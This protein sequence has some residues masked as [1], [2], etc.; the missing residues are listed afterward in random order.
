MKKTQYFYNSFVLEVCLKMVICV[1]K[2]DKI[3]KETTLTKGF[4]KVRT[5][6]VQSD[7]QRKRLGVCWGISIPSAHN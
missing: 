5:F 4:Y 3:V 6:F 1:V 2:L 7:A